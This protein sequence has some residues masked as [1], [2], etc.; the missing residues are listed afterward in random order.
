M[1]RSFAGRA[2]EDVFDGRETRQARQRLPVSIGSVARRKLAQI[3]RAGDLR[4][5]SIP[6]GNRLERLAGD[7]EGQHGIRINGK[8]W[9]KTRWGNS[10][11]TGE[12]SAG[13]I[14]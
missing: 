8:R 6:P 11:P 9:R 2:T 14:E 4:E 7:R 12:G 3:N 1:I 13:K 5:L 10:T